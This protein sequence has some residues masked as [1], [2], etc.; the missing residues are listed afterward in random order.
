MNEFW[1]SLLQ[2]VVLAIVKVGLTVLKNFKN[3]KKKPKKE[4]PTL[5]E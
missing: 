3:S 4:E 1:K 2:Q 5:L